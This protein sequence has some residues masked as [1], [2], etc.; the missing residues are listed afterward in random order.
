[1]SNVL[2]TLIL[3]TCSNLFLEQQLKT[4]QPAFSSN[5]LEKWKWN[6]VRTKF[7]IRTVVFCL[8]NAHARRRLWE[9]PDTTI[10]PSC[11]V[12]TRCVKRFW[13]V[14]FEKWC[15]TDPRMSS[16]IQEHHIKNDAWNEIDKTN[17]TCV[18]IHARGFLK[19]DLSNKKIAKNH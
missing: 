7:E 2:L 6:P 9:P 14:F 19:N 16:K 4:I 15:Q 1:M 11:D 10:I 13:D 5:S 18:K 8:R 12:G 17:W 3:Y